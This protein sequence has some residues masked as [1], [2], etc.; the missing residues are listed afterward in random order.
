MVD[1]QNSNELSR[2]V[3]IFE[4]TWAIC[5][6]VYVWDYLHTF[7]F[8]W[9][10][11]TRRVPFRWPYVPYFVG[12]YSLLWLF[13]T[14]CTLQVFLPLHCDAPYRI[15]LANFIISTGCASLN[16]AIRT[17]TI[18]EY[19]RI[20]VWPVVVLSLG[21]WSALLVAC[22]EFLQVDFDGGENSCFEVQVNNTVFVSLYICTVI[23]DFIVLIAGIVG[24]VRRR[25]VSKHD[26][27]RDL[28]RTLYNQGIVYFILTFMA[29]IACV[30]LAGL[31]FNP[32]MDIMSSIPA[33][34]I[35]MIASCHCVTSLLW[36]YK[37]APEL[38]K[39]RM[40]PSLANYTRPSVGLQLTSRFEIPWSV[41]P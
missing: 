4:K 21:H 28:R 24:L 26:D 7:W 22:I 29:N 3:N 16:L 30:V 5:F 40:S 19:K 14:L 10:I 39:R 33:L 1:W 31:N 18:W 12:R 23:F 41:P 27:P 9:W 35:S 34:V 32:V 13:V 11:V 25:S 6:G 36:N 20:V 37:D 8:E 17:V 2:D 38:G 15:L